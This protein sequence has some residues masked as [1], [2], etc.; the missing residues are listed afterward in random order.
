[1][2]FI[3]LYDEESIAAISKETGI[4]PKNVEAILQ[5]GLLNMSITDFY[6]HYGDEDSEE[7]M[8]EVAADGTSQTEELYLRI[9]RA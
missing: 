2:C 1:M 9:E 8:E 4:S 6:R 5:G 3:E 7:S